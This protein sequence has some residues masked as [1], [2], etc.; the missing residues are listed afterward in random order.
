[1]SNAARESGS[2]RGD[3]EIRPRVCR[4]VCR[5]DD[6]TLVVAGRLAARILQLHLVDV[7]CNNTYIL[8]M[9]TRT[10]FQPAFSQHVH[11]GQRRPI[12]A[13][14]PVTTLAGWEGRLSATGRN[15]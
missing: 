10:I 3:R 2:K 7:E 15:T 9:A 5:T 12:F 1:M 14:L 11:Y 6:T 13:T 4:S 8:V